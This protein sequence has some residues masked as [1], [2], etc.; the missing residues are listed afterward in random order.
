MN[1]ADSELW[2]KKFAI[3]FRTMDRGD[4][5]YITVADVDAFDARGAEALGHRPGSPAY[6]RYARETRVWRDR[7]WNRFDKNQDDRITL[8][9]FL[10]FW[11]NATADEVAELAHHRAAAMCILADADDD[12]GLTE[13]EY[14]RWAIA[15]QGV[16]K[17]IAQA[18]FA[19][20]DADRNGRLT[21][22]ELAR[23]FIE[24]ITSVG[25]APANRMF[26][27]RV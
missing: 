10:S 9:E 23:S 27:P 24:Y 21:R 11:G 25:E 15:S 22:D 26:G 1:R 4:N 18:G 16:S 19:E 20:V 6:A 2:T 3:A 5:G 7:L 8:E 12:N 13:D 14:I 17:E